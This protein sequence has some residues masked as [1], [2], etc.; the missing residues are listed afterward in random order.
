[1]D[2]AKHQYIYKIQP[3]RPELL[4]EGPTASEAKIIADHASY[5][6]SLVKTADVLLAGRT[7]TTDPSSFGIVIVSAS[8]EIE[9]RAIMNNDPV[10]KANLMKAEFFPYKI[11]F[12]SEA[13]LT[14]GRSDT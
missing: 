5:I 8:S 3:N 13:I 4:V 14:S 10:V 11:A 7:Q 1:M 6:E 12:L 9:A 2:I